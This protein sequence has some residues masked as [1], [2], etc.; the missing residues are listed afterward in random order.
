LGGQAR[1]QQ[2][3]GAVGEQRCAWPEQL[4][5]LSSIF[6]QTFPLFQ[7]QMKDLVQQLRQGQGVFCKA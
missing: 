3:F 2:R 7:L 5:F 1:R 4:A 6:S